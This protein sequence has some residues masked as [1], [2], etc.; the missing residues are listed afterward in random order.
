M[1]SLLRELVETVV[2]ALVIFF[3]LQCSVQNYRVEGS[4]MAPSL[5]EGQ[6]ILV[7]KLVYFH[8]DPQFIPRAIPL[9]KVSRKEELF[10]F[11]PPRRGEI[12]V[13]NFYKCHPTRSCVKRIIGTPGDVVHIDEGK[14]YINGTLQ[15]EPFLKDMSTSSM[16][17]IRVPEETVFVMGDNRRASNDSRNW[18]L[19]PMN[20]IVGKAWITYWPLAQWRLLRGAP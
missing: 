4:S 2:L 1:R 14:V 16:S 12:V 9:I 5:Q 7:N 10:P 6:H 20:A 19:L 13:F 8:I 3:A 11:H 15:V 17:P 18:G